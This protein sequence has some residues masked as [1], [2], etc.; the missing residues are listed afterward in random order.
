MGHQ[1]RAPGVLPVVVAVNTRLTL[2]FQVHDDHS[3]VP[4]CPPMKAG[5][6]DRHCHNEG[7]RPCA[8]FFFFPPP[9]SVPNNQSQSFNSNVMIGDTVVCSGFHADVM[10]QSLI[11]FS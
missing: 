1:K 3:L 6:E 10:T 9:P 8:N 5:E 7:R 2:E 4:F 11:Y